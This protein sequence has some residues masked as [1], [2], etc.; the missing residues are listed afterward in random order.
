MPQTGGRPEE[1]EWDFAAQANAMVVKNAES[2]YRNMFFQGKRTRSAA[3]SHSPVA[4]C[5]SL[6]W[7]VAYGP[8]A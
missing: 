7:P 4:Y 8:L 3:S 6:P 5:A 1:A 2:Y